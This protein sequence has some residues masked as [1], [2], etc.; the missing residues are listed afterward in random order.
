MKPRLLI[1][2][3][4]NTLY[5]WVTFFARSFGAM[6]STLS[7][8]LD[9]DEETL[10]AEFKSVHQRHGTLEAPFAALELPSIIKRF[11]GASRSDVARELTLAFEA[12]NASRRQHLVLY[13]GVRDTLQSLTQHGVVIVAHT[14]AISINAYYRVVVLDILKYFRR[15]YVLEGQVGEHPDPTRQKRLESP[16]PDLIRVLPR[17]DRKPNPAALLDICRTEGFEP[18]DTCYVGDSIVRDVSMAKQAGV[19]AVWARYGTVYERSLWDTL[20]SVTHWTDEDVKR[21]TQLRD[22]FSA[23]SP[24]AVIDCFSDLLPL[25]GIETNLPERRDSAPAARPF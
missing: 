19:T 25:F 12:F 17:K 6:M 20:V 3:L 8:H 2:D 22:K 5:D 13:E 24:D 16:P 11:P 23:I 10:A 4:D 7:R 21:E 9:V 15:L 18:Q 14:E 1:T